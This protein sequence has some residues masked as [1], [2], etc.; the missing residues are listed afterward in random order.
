MFFNKNT[1]NIITFQDCLS[2]TKWYPYLAVDKEI[3]QF[4]INPIFLYKTS[5]DFSKKK[6][7]D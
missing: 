5:W 1:S 7:C 4:Y 3:K 2:S 6:E